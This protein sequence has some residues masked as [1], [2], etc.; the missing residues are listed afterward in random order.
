MTTIAEYR[1][2]FA[3]LDTLAA[4]VWADETVRAAELAAGLPALAAAARDADQQAAAVGRQLDEAWGLAA[5]W[6]CWE[7]WTTLG[8]RP[9]PDPSAAHPVDLGELVD[10]VDA[11][12]RELRR[13]SRRLFWWWPW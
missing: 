5:E 6:L 8:L 12:A 11:R 1:A 13:A 4:Q 10:Q 7:M 3:G 2:V 9:H